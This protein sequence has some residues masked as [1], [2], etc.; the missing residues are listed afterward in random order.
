M[1]QKPLKSKIKKIPN[2]KENSKRE[3]LLLPMLNLL[4]Q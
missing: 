4:L 1:E 2:P 3:V